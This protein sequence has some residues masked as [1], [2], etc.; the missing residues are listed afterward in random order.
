MGRDCD[1][2]DDGGDD[3]VGDERK[4]EEEGGGRKEHELPPWVWRSLLLMLAVRML[5]YV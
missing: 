4:N 2:D 3:G 5:F 1:D